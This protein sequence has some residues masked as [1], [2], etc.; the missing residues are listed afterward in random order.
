MVISSDV[1]QGKNQFPLTVLEIAFNR[2]FAV[3]LVLSSLPLLLNIFTLPTVIIFIVFALFLWF[4]KKY[5]LFA[6]I[7]FLIFALGVYFI[8]IPPIGWGLF[9]GLKELRLGGFDFNFPS[10]FF[11]PLLIFISFSVRNVVG[12]IL[13][14]FKTNTDS[15]KVYLISL[16]I[17]SVTLLAYPFFDPVRLRDRTRNVN[18]AVGGDLP[19]VYTRQSL[20]FMD[21]YN[22]AGNFTS[23]FV[24]SSK[25][26][27]YHLQLLEPLAKNIQFTKVETDG[28]KINFVADSRVECLNCQKDANDPYGLVFP[29]GKAIDFIIESDRLIKTITF[30]ESG[31]KAADF[32]F[33]K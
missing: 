16:I 28:E 25:K 31:D 24:S 19:L 27:I 9:R 30:I 26:Y 18:T 6:N 23:K 4:G 33:W 7:V 17:V 8:Q 10:L 32:V 11:I 15:R 29:A 12:N 20:T 2:L 5:H 22:M 14:H 1:S 13:A 21:R 3:L